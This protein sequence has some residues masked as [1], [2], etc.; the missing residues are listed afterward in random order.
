MAFSQKFHLLE[1]FLVYPTLSWAWW[2]KTMDNSVGVLI[3]SLLKVSLYHFWIIWL[4]KVGLHLEVVVK[5]WY[6]LNVILDCLWALLFDWH[7]F[8][9]VISAKWSCCIIKVIATLLSHQIWVDLRDKTAN[10]VN[11]QILLLLVVEAIWL[12]VLIQGRIWLILNF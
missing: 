6:V 2:L 8:R 11:S 9:V 4:Q 3:L 1:C 5:I 7:N 12:L 10:L